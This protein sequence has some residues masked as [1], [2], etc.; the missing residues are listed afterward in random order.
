MTIKVLMID[1]DGVI[2]VH[3][4]PQGWSVN[5]EKDLGLT[6]GGAVVKWF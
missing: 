1:V 4:H 2:V 3:P 5:P 6:R